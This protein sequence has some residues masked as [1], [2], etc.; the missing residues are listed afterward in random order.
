MKNRILTIKVSKRQTK[1][2][3]LVCLALSIVLLAGLCLTSFADQGT[4]QM[5]KGYQWTRI[6]SNE[7]L[8]AWE[9]GLALE[10]DKNYKNDNNWVRALLIYNNKY[11]IDGYRLNSGNDYYLPRVD[12]NEAFQGAGIPVTSGIDIK[13]DKFMTRSGLNTPFIKYR[14][15]DTNDDNDCAKFAVRMAKDDKI[16]KSMWLENLSWYGV[17]WH[18]A[19]YSEFRF[20]DY[21]SISAYRARFACSADTMSDVDFRFITSGDYK[22]YVHPFYNIPGVCDRCWNHDGGRTIYSEKSEDDD[23]SCYILYLGYPCDVPVE[24]LSAAL[25]VGETVVWDGKIIGRDTVITVKEGST[26][27]VDGKCYNNGKLVVD[28]GTVIVKGILD[29]DIP[30]TDPGQH[31]F[32]PG[33]IEV[34][35][36][37]ILYVENSGCLLMR[38]SKTGV[39][40]TDNSTL[41]VHGSALM[42]GYL[43]IEGYSR[44]ESDYGSFIGIGIEPNSTTE[45]T[46]YSPRLLKQ[47]QQNYGS[48]MFNAYN[49]ATITGLYVLDN[50]AAYFN[51]GF[52]APSNMTR[53]IDSTSYMSGKMSYNINASVSTMIVKW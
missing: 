45:Q 35:N 2:F 22:G 15:W 39:K 6:R 8:K 17:A 21:D 33:V 1:P 28:G 49:G 24:T 37:G 32:S 50:S 7:D 9:K 38:N 44:F 12:D 25:E 51:G 31:S 46:Y 52:F 4:V 23:E 11:Y 18:A 26:L 43:W 48:G 53:T 10:G 19:T 3:R 42:G 30:G 40:L 13:K 41:I 29:M 47:Y 14:G 27:V 5:G 34:K 16:S 36:G 20:C